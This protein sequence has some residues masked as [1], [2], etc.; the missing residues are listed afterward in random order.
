MNKSNKEV[1]N[2]SFVDSLRACLGLAPLYAR[3]PTSEYRLEHDYID[4]RC[5]GGHASKKPV[6]K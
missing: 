6:A 2:R 5:P 4:L 1:D 3:D